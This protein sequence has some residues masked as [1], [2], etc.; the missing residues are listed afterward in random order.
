M[1][2]DLQKVLEA[3]KFDKRMAEWYL[4]RGLITKEELQK[5]LNSLPDLAS[6]AA[7]FD[8]EEEETGNGA[9]H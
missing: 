3:L 6:E 9:A 4:R 5:H 2:E 1:T 7:H 8:L